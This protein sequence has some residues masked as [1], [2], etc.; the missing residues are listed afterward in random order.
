MLVKIRTGDELEH[1]RLQPK[2][3]SPQAFDL[4][5][6]LQPPLCGQDQDRMLLLWL[7]HAPVIGCAAC[8]GACLTAQV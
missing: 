8:H 4:L 3:T 6:D 7:E 1:V 2:E 5:L